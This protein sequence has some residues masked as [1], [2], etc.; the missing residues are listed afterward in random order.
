LTDLSSIRLP[1]SVGYHSRD[2]P[3]RFVGRLP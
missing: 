2:P 3:V 1:Q